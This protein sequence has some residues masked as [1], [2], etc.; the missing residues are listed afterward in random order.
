VAVVWLVRRLLREAAFQSSL[1]Y[2]D[3]KLVSSCSSQKLV[4]S[5]PLQMLVLREA[6]LD[7]EAVRIRIFFVQ[8]KETVFER[9]FP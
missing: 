4:W 1:R 2:D 7:F 3:W 9:E 8:G 6:T 5:L